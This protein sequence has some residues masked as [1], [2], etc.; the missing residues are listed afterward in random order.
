MISLASIDQVNHEHFYTMLQEVDPELYMIKR[1]LVE[2]GINPMI[3]PYVLRPIQNLLIGTGY[4]VIEIVMFDKKL[5]KIVVKET[6]QVE[7]NIEIEMKV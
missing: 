6:S 5:R 7:K 4:G 3:V 2:S 1:A